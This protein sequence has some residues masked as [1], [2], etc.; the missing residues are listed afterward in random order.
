MTTLVFNPAV[1]EINYRGNGALHT[2]I[3]ALDRLSLL[4]AILKPTSDSE[5]CQTLAER[6]WSEVP[7]YYYYKT[8]RNTIPYDN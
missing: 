3:P 1:E 4:N 2:N 6:M 5:N 7:H 8:I